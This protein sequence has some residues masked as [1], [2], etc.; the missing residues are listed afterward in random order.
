MNKIE[1]IKQETINQEENTSESIPLKTFYSI[2]KK[3][4]YLIYNK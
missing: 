4:N 2:I 1:E 3:L